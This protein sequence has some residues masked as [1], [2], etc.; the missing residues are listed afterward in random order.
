MTTTDRTTP[1]VPAVDLDRDRS[2]HAGFFTGRGDASTP[3]GFV[4]AYTPDPPP[5]PPTVALL[6][7]GR[8]LL[9]ATTDRDFPAAPGAFVDA[10]RSGRRSSPTSGHTNPPP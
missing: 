10:W 1:T 3:D 4:T 2:G 6:P 5:D 8:R 9:S 7:A